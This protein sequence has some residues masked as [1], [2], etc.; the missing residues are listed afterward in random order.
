MHQH[1]PAPG[2]Y[3]ES[4]VAVTEPDSNSA[5]IGVEGTC[6]HPV[7][8]SWL[9]CGAFSGDYQ[10]TGSDISPGREMGHLTSSHL[11]PGIALVQR[12]EGANRR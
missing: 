6:A 11:S 4:T 12:K 8:L 9:Q 5:R 10:M 1:S 2:S 3:L 7:H